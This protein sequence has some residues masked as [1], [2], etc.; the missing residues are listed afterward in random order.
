VSDWKVGDACRLRGLGVMIAIVGIKAA[1]DD[2]DLPRPEMA[3]CVW[4]D[5]GHHLQIHSFPTA[6]LVPLKEPNPWK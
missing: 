5:T 3:E 1:E 2:P 4:F 6:A